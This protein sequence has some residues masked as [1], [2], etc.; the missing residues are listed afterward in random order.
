[1]STKKAGANCRCPY[2]NSVNGS[3][4]GGKKGLFIQKVTLVTDTRL[5]KQ[6]CISNTHNDLLHCPHKTPL[7][8]F[9]AS[10]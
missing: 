2:Y 10:S 7:R 6:R 1:M 8:S 9:A 4:F 3:I 5:K